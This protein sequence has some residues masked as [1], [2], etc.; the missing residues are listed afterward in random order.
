MDK[1]TEKKEK[2][3]RV[4]RTE[5]KKSPIRGFFT[6][7][8]RPICFFVFSARGFFPRFFSRGFSR[9]IS[10]FRSRFFTTEWKKKGKRTKKICKK[11]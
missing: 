8:L 5:I 9:L 3:K 1:K 11:G 10:F 6:G 4:K 7:F 2:R